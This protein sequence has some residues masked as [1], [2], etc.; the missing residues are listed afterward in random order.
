MG[1][2][3]GGRGL[4]TL[5]LS[6]VPQIQDSASQ[7]TCDSGRRI[8]VSEPEGGMGQAGRQ[9]G[10]DKAGEQQAV[11]ALSLYQAA[12]SWPVQHGMEETSR[13]P[14]STPSTA[15]HAPPAAAAP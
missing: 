3:L 14:S 6:S 4:C 2:V 10:T 1:I 13:P 5:L 12:A 8:R 15:S 11:P 7:N 9:A